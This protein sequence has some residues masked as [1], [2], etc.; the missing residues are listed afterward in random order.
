LWLTIP[1]QVE[2]VDSSGQIVRYRG[3]A[4]NLS[5]HGGRIQVPRKLAGDGRI[6]LWN[7][8]G[9]TEAEFRV[10]ETIA[11]HGDEGGEYGVEC[12][13]Q[14]KNFWGIEF[15]SHRDEVQDARAL[16]NC[17]LCR[18]LALIPLTTAE[19]ERLR[20]AGMTGR[21]CAKCSA[22]THWW[23]A[24]MSVL[25]YREQERPQSSVEREARW[26]IPAVDTA[27]RGHPRVH[28]QM[29]L[30]L[31]GSYGYS[32]EVQAE[33]ISQFGFS[34]SSEKKYQRGEMVRA[35][36]PI[37]PVIGQTQ[38]PSRIVRQQ[39]LKGSDRKIYGAAFEPQKSLKPFG[40]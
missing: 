2:G 17:G 10:V 37:A 35:A 24:D 8:V 16:L 20:T 22:L 30:W 34:F 36:F 26:L 6:G 12:L 11:S 7:P 39:N 4:I 15:C 29:P 19:I 14:E 13:E 31:R 18:S 9:N 28:M 40:A 25:K 32:D 5:R 1:L 23:Y 27:E 38:I 3:R 33:N 21:Y